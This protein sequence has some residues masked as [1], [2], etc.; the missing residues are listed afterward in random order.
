[1]KIRQNRSRPIF[2]N[3]VTGYSSNYVTIS[4]QGGGSQLL[5]SITQGRAQSSF[6]VYDVNGRLVSAV[7]PTG[8]VTT[9]YTTANATT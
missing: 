3:L 4:Y 6:Y 7:S 2:A 8:A 1:M 9:L 5:R